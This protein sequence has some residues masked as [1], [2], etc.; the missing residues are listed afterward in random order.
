MPRADRLRECHSHLFCPEVGAFWLSTVQ[1]GLRAGHQQG[2]A[3]LGL[4]QAFW[5]SSLGTLADGVLGQACVTHWEWR[6]TQASG[7]GSSSTCHSEKAGHLLLEGWVLL[8]VGRPPRD[9]KGPARMS[10]QSEGAKNGPGGHRS[11]VWT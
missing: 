3:M 1:A 5:E 10:G 7:C 4:S 9:S 2:L 6:G 11:G 8:G